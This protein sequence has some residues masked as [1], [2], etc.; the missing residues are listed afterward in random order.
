MTNTEF[1]RT[2]WFLALLL[3]VGAALFAVGV[4]VE[5]NTG[6]QHAASPA[7]A[8]TVHNE[9][10]EAGTEDSSVGGNESTPH[11]EGSSSEA[12]AHAE[13]SE[14]ILGINTESSGVV[15]IAVLLAVAL[16]FLVVL[17]PR[18]PLFLTVVAFAGAF[19]VFDVVEAIHQIDNSRPGIA[20]I[21]ISLSLVHAAAALL[22]RQRAAADSSSVA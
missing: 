15:A 3:V 12:S 22:A 13:S 18:R 2:T 17:R 7:T 19:A 4:G 10:S 16:A 20:A 21:A 8:T 11:I 1:L 5:R 6:D 9:A 14:K